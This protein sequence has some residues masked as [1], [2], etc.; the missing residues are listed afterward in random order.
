MT[1]TV[2]ALPLF[3]T[4]RS[5]PLKVVLVAGACLLL[6]ACGTLGGGDS[7]SGNM[8]TNLTEAQWRLAA[9]AESQADYGSAAE[10]Y[11]KLVELNPDDVEAITGRA[12]NL[13]Y[14]GKVG[15]ARKFLTDT[16]VR[17]GPNYRLKLE[18]AKAT[19]AGPTWKQA[20]PLVDELVAERPN[21]W[22]PLSLRALINDR[23][24][25]FSAAE[26][27]Y[28]AVLKIDPDNLPTLNN[29]ALSL[30]MNGN[31]DEA[32]GLLETVQ[33]RSD[34]PLQLRQ[35]LAMFYALSGRLGKAEALVRASLPEDAAKEMLQALRS[36]ANSTN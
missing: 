4:V 1:N 33:D 23:S 13:R 28:R 35:N 12:R 19:M 27:D 17:T 8:Q 29:L 18:L 25:N 3:P 16:M 32:V 24:S 10:R 22:Q 2:A 21:D 26:A 11:G 7:A 5:A 15:D 34:A 20:A 9:A 6:G 31:I 36:M 30:A 14:A